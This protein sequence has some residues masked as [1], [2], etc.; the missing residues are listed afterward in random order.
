MKTELSK[1]EDKKVQMND[2]ILFQ[3]REIQK[4]KK[5]ITE[6]DA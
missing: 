2:D 3:R 4:L 5:E 1:L 6:L